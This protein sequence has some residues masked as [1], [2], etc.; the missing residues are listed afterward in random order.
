[1]LITCPPALTG[2]FDALA[3]HCRL[4]GRLTVLAI[5]AATPGEMVADSLSAWRRRGPFQRLHV[6]IDHGSGEPPPSAEMAAA[7]RLLLADD[8][9]GNA[10]FRMVPAGRAFDLWLLLHR[11]EP[12]AIP[13]GARP[14][15]KQRQ[16][17]EEARSLLEE[18]GAERLDGLLADGLAAAIQRGRRLTFENG[19]QDR[20][21]WPSVSELTELAAFLSKLGGVR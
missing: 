3:R 2:Y 6:V 4:H 16:L 14:T 17:L 8:C 9:R 11:V 7:E 1:M 19:V 12:P 13:P 21:T 20:H 15:A 5:D 18:G 10:I